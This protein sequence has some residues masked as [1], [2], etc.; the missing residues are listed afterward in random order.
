[1]T[2]GANDAASATGAELGL[3]AEVRAIESIQASLGWGDAEAAAAALARY[4][5]QFPD[6]ELALEADL[7]D[8]DV[9]L[10]RGERPQAR[11]LARALLARPA[12]TRY[13]ARLEGLAEGK[14][15]ARPDAAGSIGGAA[16]MKERR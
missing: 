10:A 12:A 15:P 5:R 3:A 7:L 16:H 13:R 2:V 6:G 11:R 14:T 1:V 8:I 4:R 9:A